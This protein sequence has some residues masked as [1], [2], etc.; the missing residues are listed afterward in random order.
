MFYFCV[1]VSYVQSSRFCL[2]RKRKPAFYSLLLALI[3]LRLTL[4][5]KVQESITA[6]FSSA[7]EGVCSG[8]SLVVEVL[9]T[10]AC[11]SP[12]ICTSLGPAESI[13]ASTV[14]VVHSWPPPIHTHPCARS[15]TQTCAYS[16]RKALAQRLPLTNTRQQTL[17]KYV[18]SSHLNEILNCFLL[19][20][21][22]LYR[23][24]YLGRA[25]H[26]SQLCW[27]M[28]GCDFF[29]SRKK[30]CIPLSMVTNCLQWQETNS[31][32]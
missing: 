4:T 31:H 10:L 20:R 22:L 17:P 26:F 18:H 6:M 11:C 24:C 14:T 13:K 7:T 30:L 16:Y 25:I 23:V 27:Q 29:V 12:D 32:Q 28:P 9:W 3:W 8:W 19:L 1:S 2:V 5:G 15:H 21:V